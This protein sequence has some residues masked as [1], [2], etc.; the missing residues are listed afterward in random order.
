MCVLFCVFFFLN[1]WNP[2]G[3]TVPALGEPQLS[4]VIGGSPWSSE[5]SAAAP[6]HSPSLYHPQYI[7]D[8]HS[9]QARRTP[10]TALSNS[11]T[12]QIFTHST[13]CH[14]LSQHQPRV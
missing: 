2:K 13:E 6:F 5:L 1:A 4:V 7:N 9:V 12:R 8:L 14:E 11:L 10:G 3:E